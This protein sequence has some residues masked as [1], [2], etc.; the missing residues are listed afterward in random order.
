METFPELIAL[1]AGY[2]T[3]VYVFKFNFHL[4]LKDTDEIL[5]LASAL[6]KNVL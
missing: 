5:A 1:A 3:F 4:L 6:V 2:F